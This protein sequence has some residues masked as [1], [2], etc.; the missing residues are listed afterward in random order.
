MITGCG[1]V[2]PIGIGKEAFWDALVHGKNGVGPISSFDTSNH[3]VKIAAEVKD[4][5][6][7]DWFDRKE[8]RRTDRV[9]QFAA[10]CTDM[11]IKD[12]GLD[13][14][15]ID[16]NML[17]VYIGTGEGGI[18]TLEDNLH[19]LNEKGPSRVS[20]FL[21]PM[22][23]VNMPAAYVAIRIGAKGA[24]MAVVT[25]CAS[26]INSMGEAACCISRGDADI[27][28]AGGGGSGGFSPCRGR[29]F[30]AQGAVDEIRRPGTC[31]PP[32]R[33][34]TRRFRDGRGRCHLRI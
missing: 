16:K 34:G 18:H 19:I 24:N 9:I 8:A 14:D 11:A 20:P 3:P 15:S 17:G 12:S 7:E 1:A 5:N 4:F 30:C 23:I 21:V 28:L 13:M 29:L 33:R 22:M 26:S 27:I 31:F 25:A 10:A 2:T 32:L 6:A